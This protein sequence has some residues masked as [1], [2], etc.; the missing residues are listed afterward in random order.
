[1]PYMPHMHGREL[2]YMPYMPYTRQG[3]ALY[4]GAAVGFSEL[5]GGIAQSPTASLLSQYVD[6]D[7]A[8][9]ERKVDALAVLKATSFNGVVPHLVWGWN[10][11]HN[12]AGLPK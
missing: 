1:M 2:P 5:M 3:A 10:S 11:V 8:R 9:C 6:G 12:A 7:Y 4:V